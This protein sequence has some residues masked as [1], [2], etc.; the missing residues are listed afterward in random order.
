MTFFHGG[1]FLK[2]ISPKTKSGGHFLK[3]ICDGYLLQISYR[4][5]GYLDFRYIILT[6]IKIS[7]VCLQKKNDFSEKKKTSIT[8]KLRYI[9]KKDL[10]FF[11]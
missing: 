6:E 1:R 8:H 10:F 5:S 7:N 3:D 2:D 9:L 11:I 4:M